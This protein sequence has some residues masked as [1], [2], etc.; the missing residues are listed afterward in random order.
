MPTPAAQAAAY[1]RCSTLCCLDTS[2]CVGLSWS[3]LHSLSAFI[4]HLVN[5]G[6][7]PW[8]ERKARQLDGSIATNR[9]GFRN[10]LRYLWRKPRGMTAASQNSVLSSGGAGAGGA[11]SEGSASSS[12]SPFASAF[13]SSATSVV[14]NVAEQAG[15]AAEALL[16]A[17]GG[18][19]LGETASS[20]SQSGSSSKAAPSRSE[21]PGSPRRNGLSTQAFVQSAYQLHAIEWQYRLLG[22]LQLF[23][24]LHEAALQSFRSCAADFKQ[25]KRWKQLGED[26]T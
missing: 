8:M 3:D 22:D 20:F 25:D 5:T 1:V 17:V 7:L 19:F 2:F 16:S 26:E 18:A 10:Q 24:G 4:Q 23:F 9:K 21:A 13:P 12:F 15:G 14:A 6:I 11:P